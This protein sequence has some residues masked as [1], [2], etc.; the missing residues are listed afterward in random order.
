MQYLLGKLVEARYIEWHRNCDNTDVVQDLFWAHPGSIDL[1]RAFPRVLIMDCT[2]KTNRYRIPLL[3]S[4][5]VTSTDLT[6]SIA[7]HT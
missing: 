7:L 3:E 1:L 4:M 2:D 6:F 5:G